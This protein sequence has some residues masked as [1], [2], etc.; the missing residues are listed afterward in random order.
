[1]NNFKV[2]EIE[3]ILNAGKDEKIN[4]DILGTVYSLGRDAENDEEYDYAFNML[5]EIYENAS[6]RV[7]VF[8]ILAFSLL[9][10]YHKRLDRKIVEPIIMREWHIADSINKSTIQN[11]VDDINYTLKWNLHL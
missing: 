8:V 5:L 4:P 10:V 7:R 3:A 9:A 6:D 2:K 11:A 1:M